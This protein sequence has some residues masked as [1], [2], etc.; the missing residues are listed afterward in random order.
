[1]SLC[2]SLLASGAKAGRVLVFS[3]G[4]TN[5]VRVGP[6]R[7]GKSTQVGRERF[8]SFS[9]TARPAA[10]VTKA[11]QTKDGELYV[12][13]YEWHVLVPCLYTYTR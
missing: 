7:L 12:L 4:R 3:V 8:R 2:T 13:S 5:R 10:G 1:M 9:V 11:M 6:M